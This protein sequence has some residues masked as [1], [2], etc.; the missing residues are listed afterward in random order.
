MP[1]LEGKRVLITHT[2]VSNIMGSTVVAME[3]AEHL[4]EQ[5]AHVIVYASDANE[6]MLGE[7]E[8][9][10]IPI[11]R[12]RDKEAAHLSCDDFDY[13]WIHSQLLPPSIL[14]S[15]R[16]AALGGGQLPAF[17]FYH[18]SCLGIAPDEHPYIEGLE[19]ALS[20]LSLFVSPECFDN[21]TE[22]YWTRTP[23]PRKLSIL[24]NWAPK[25]FS[26]L[27]DI[28]SA[29]LKRLLVVS[30]HIPD[31][32]RAAAGLLIKQGVEV[33]FLGKADVPKLVGPDDLAWADAVITIGKT[34]IYCLAMGIPVFLYDHFGGCGYL[35]DANLEEA[36]YGNFSGR[37]QDG[38][39]PKME[40]GQLALK[41]DGGYASALKW[42]RDNAG[43]LA[44]RYSL[45]AN[46]SEAL[47]QLEPDP[48]KAGA[49]AKIPADTWNTWKA[50]M[51]F[52]SRYYRS[53]AFENWARMELADF[54]AS[55]AALSS[56]LEGVRAENS[57]MKSQLEAEVARS[58][59]LGRKL[60]S[61][62]ERCSELEGQ[63]ERMRGLSGAVEC[64]RKSR[65]EN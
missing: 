20:D 18:M 23:A 39:F 60:A 34:A 43:I 2:L 16:E 1:E 35:G 61:S 47:S 42:S 10:D 57:R 19:A 54:R 6:L 4:L 56:E 32:L 22:S 62:I 55:A 17:I 44:K 36:A 12:S 15:A 59:E 21:L 49:I 25:R 27:D 24:P 30:N 26:P 33:R 13:I 38:S 41:L 31:E 65:H 40:S 64:L 9:R 3:L 51:D 8:K 50:Q 28:P 48:E 7:F 5:G 53:W 11:I 63:L 58:D 14:A 46:L 52:A 37:T 29:S 45:G